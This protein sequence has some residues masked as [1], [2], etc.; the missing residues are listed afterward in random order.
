MISLYDILEAADGQLF[1]EAV[2]SIFADF[3]YD[4]RRV[5]PGELY[6][7]LKTERGDGHHYMQDAVDRGAAGIMCTHPPTFDTDGLTVIVMRSVERALM[8]WTQ[9]VLQKYGTTVIAVTGSAGKSV[10][11]E[12]IAQVLRRRFSVYTH[13]GSF[14]GRFGL[15]LALGKLTRDHRVAVLEF[16]INQPG[17]MAEMVAATKPMVGVVTAVQHAH[18]DHLHTLDQIAQEKGALVRQLPP[19]G[20]AVLNF[21]DPR[22]RAMASETKAAVMTVGLDIV[23]PSY[24]S[25]LL[26]YNIVMDRY[27][28]GFD[29]RRGAER[30]PGRWIP[31]LGAHQ[32]YSALAALAVGLSYQIPLEE[33]LQALTEMEPL[34]GRMRLLDGPDGALL[35]DDTHS[36]NPETVLAALDWLRAAR[37]PD[38]R[39][40]L[41]L[42]D[43]DDLGSYT[44][45]AHMQ[46]GQHAAGIVDQLVTQGDLAAEA[47]RTALEH[48]LN[49]NQ[50]AI[51][52]NPTD[53]ARAASAG[54]GPRDMVLIKGGQRAQM[55]R[56]VRRLLINEADVSLLTKRTGIY[57][58]VD[59]ERAADRPSWVLV[60]LEAVA[61]NMRRIK[62]T[63]GPE[64]ALLAEVRA[65]AYGHGAVTVS[66]TALHNGADMLGVASLAEALE[67]RDAGIDA[68]ILIMGYT[69]AWAAPQVIRHKLTVTLY[70][71]ESAR[72]FDRA[73]QALDTTVQAHVL[74]DT[75]LGMLGLL[76]GDV[77][78]FFRSLR[79]MPRLQIEGI[80]TQFSVPVENPDYTRVQLV[81]FESMVD[82]LLAAGFRFKYVHAADTATA[83]HMPETRF[84]LVRTGAALYGLSAGPYAPIPAD[85]RPALTWKTTIAQIKRLPPGS[86]VGEGNTYRTQ[87]IRQIA[88]IPV[89]FADGFRRAP[90]RLK[91]VVVKG[92]YAPIVG[93]ISMDL[94]AIDV[95]DIEDVQVGEEVVLIGA[96]GWRAI[97]ITD[98]ADT[99]GTTPAEVISTVLARV[100]RVK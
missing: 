52:F 80:Y 51:T 28:T 84:T 67:L 91:Q 54:L 3:C 46:A 27:K 61:Y 73:A 7:A 47:G 19:E 99:L 93:Q 38:G 49:R 90:S 70:D 5:N 95:T 33:G 88:L 13:P 63:V 86:F 39:A 18:T 1:G 100:P 92:H 11:K 77:T 96:Q 4:S 85:F 20:L 78:L 25:D 65:N 10:T 74:V 50:V 23:E 8:R 62:E 14:N 45:L 57:E 97:S 53:A 81:T 72:V 75:G 79:T 66:T 89:G 55:E 21:D 31:L 56:I 71:A 41:V 64:V 42:G 48:G 17:E 60:D 22:V 82:P 29:L 15:P 83:I 94:T 43:M 37:D 9:L 59:A 36:A 76:P 69:P 30:F 58:Q 44:S 35:I 40:I 98:A 16:G 2:A 32:L 87:D 26:A 12:A 24:G 34:P 6:V 68:P